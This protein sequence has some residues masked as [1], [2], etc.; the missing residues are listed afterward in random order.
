MY[1]EPRKII[2]MIL[3]AEQQKRHRCKQQAFGVCGQSWKWDDFREYHWNMHITICKIDDQC[4]SNEW[5]RELKASA[6]GQPRGMG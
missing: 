6:L 5:S 2:M 4:K 1:L 3:Y